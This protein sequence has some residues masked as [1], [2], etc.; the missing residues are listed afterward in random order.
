[1]RKNG[2]L[3]A[4]GKVL[5]IQGHI[6]QWRGCGKSCEELEGVDWCWSRPGGLSR[7]LVDLHLGSSDEMAIYFM[8][9]DMRGVWSSLES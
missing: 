5:R 8:K 3:D 2:N 1:M 4:L 6:F 7:M 9:V